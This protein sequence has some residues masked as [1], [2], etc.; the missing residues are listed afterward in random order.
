MLW[1]VA[2]DRRVLHDSPRLQ[3]AAA[4][5]NAL[6][7]VTNDDLREIVLDHEVGEGLDF[8]YFHP[9]SLSQNP[10]PGRTRKTCGGIASPKRKQCHFWKCDKGPILVDLR[11]K[12]QDRFNLLIQ[13]SLE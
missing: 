6:F 2:D 13:R 11:K 5:E 12:G 7:T 9:V 3:P 8:V 10:N 1:C 4:E